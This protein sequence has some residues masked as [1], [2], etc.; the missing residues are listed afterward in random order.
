MKTKEAERYFEQRWER[1]REMRDPRCQK[2]ARDAYLEGVCSAL[3]LLN[4][5]LTLDERTMI[6][7]G[8]AAWVNE[9]LKRV[10]TKM[11]EVV[12]G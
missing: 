12:D 9:E 2:E 8:G 6:L 10:R 11:L 7:A 3:L 5:H 4:D 1:H